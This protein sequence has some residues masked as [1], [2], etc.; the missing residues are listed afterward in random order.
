LYPG[1]SCLSLARNTFF[2]IIFFPSSKMKAA[3]SGETTT[4]YSPGFITSKHGYRLSAS[5]CLNGD[6]K[7]KGTHLSIFIC[8]LKGKPIFLG[9]QVVWLHV[10]SRLVNNAYFEKKSCQHFFSWEWF[11][12]CTEGMHFFGYKYFLGRGGVGGSI[13]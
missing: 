9:F 8:I 10:K 13:L 6:G 12:I 11:K 4:L 3:Q 2:L 5:V 1:P 7:G